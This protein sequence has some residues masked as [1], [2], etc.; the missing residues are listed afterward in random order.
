MFQPKTEVNEKVV[1]EVKKEEEPEK[2]AEKKLI[3]KDLIKTGLISLVLLA[4]L[5]GAYFYLK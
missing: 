2:T 4:I 3:I 1:V 5:I